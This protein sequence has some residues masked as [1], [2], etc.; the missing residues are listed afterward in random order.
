MD[1]RFQ[2]ALNSTNT[3]NV[4]P[5]AGDLGVT[6]ARIILPGDPDRS[7]LVL[8]TERRDAVGMPPLSSHLVDAQ[9]VQLLR[10]WISQL[11]GC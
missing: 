1:L 7:V 5:Q 8:R 2:V 6:G 3:C 4:V 10:Y 9:G 11:G